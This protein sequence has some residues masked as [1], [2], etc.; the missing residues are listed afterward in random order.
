MSCELLEDVVDSTGRELFLTMNVHNNLFIEIESY[1]HES[2]CRFHI[3]PDE[4]GIKNANTL[5][6]A[7]QSW[8]AHVKLCEDD[9]NHVST[10]TK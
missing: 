6:E 2:C 1:T 7:L 8:L 10:S 3:P 9:N 4:K 5:I